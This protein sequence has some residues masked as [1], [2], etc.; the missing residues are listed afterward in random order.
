MFFAFIAERLLN[1]VL[2]LP[3]FNTFRSYLICVVNCHTK[4]ADQEFLV[5]LAHGNIW[6]PPW[7]LLNSWYVLLI[8]TQSMRSSCVVRVLGL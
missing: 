6:R 1:A 5:V 4:S 3:L 2:F 8:R 7:G